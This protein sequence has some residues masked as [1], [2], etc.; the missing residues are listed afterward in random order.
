MTMA[1]SLIAGVV[2]VVI[3]VAQG[4]NKDN[5]LVVF[6]GGRTK[7]SLENLTPLG[8]PVAAC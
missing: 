5:H 3:D 6:L 8:N 2:I 1:L 7:S 4:V